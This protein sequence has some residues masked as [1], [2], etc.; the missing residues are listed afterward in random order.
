MECAFVN[1][2]SANIPY[3]FLFRLFQNYFNFHDKES[4]FK[5]LN[6]TGRGSA[7]FSNTL[8]IGNPRK[9]HALRFPPTRFIPVY[10][11]EK[12]EDGKGGAA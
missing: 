4:Y 6:V 7:Q 1:F 10:R 5:L 3:N 8:Y 2:S 12:D 9:L 11:G